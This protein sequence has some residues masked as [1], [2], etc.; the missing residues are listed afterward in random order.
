LKEEGYRL[1]NKQRFYCISN[2]LTLIAFLIENTMKKIYLLALA[3]SLCA[4]VQAQFKCYSTEV[5]NKRRAQNPAFDEAVKREDQRFIK[6]IQSGQLMQ[7]ANHGTRAVKT[8]PVVVHVIWNT[9][10][11]NVTDASIQQM[12][13]TLNQDFS[14]QNPTLNT[15]AVRASFKALSKDAEIQFCLAS[16]TPAGASTTGISRYNTSELDY[17]PDTEEDKM[18]LTTTNGGT[19]EAAWDPTK[20]LNIWICDLTPGAQGQGSVGGYAYR[21]NG[22]GVHGA[23]YDGLVIDYQ[24]GMGANNHVAT[25]EIG[26]YMGLAHT[27]G[28]NAGN[29]CGNVYPATDDGFSETPDSKEPNYFCTKNISC[30]GNHVDGDMYENYMDYAAACMALFT[31]QQVAYMNNILSGT[32]ASLLTSQGCVAPNAPPVASFTANRQSICSGQT[33]TF[34]STSTG[35]P[36]SYSWSFPG[37][38]PATSTSA[39]PTITYSTSGTYNVSLTVTNGFGSNTKTETAFILVNTGGGALPLAEGF[40][41]TTFPPTGWTLQ[42]SDA[43]ITWERNASAGGFGTSTASAYMNNVDYSTIGQKDWLITPSY[44]FAGVSAGRLKFEYAYTRFYDASFGYYD[45]SL[46]VLYSTDCGVTWTNLWKKGGASLST[47]TPAYMNTIFLPTAAQWKRDSV[48]LA[49]LSGQANVKFAF[50]GITGYGNNLYLDNINIYN[51]TVVITKPVAD[52]IGTPTTV[53]V[54]N[55]VAFTDLSANAPTSWNWTFAGGTPGTST[56][57]NPTITYNTVGT[58]AVTLTATNTAGSSTPVTKT[59]YITVINATPA[60]DCDTL[61]HYDSD[62]DELAMYGVNGT[63]GAVSGHNGLLDKSKAEKYTTALTNPKVYGGF[64]YFGLAK[65][66]SG[67]GK[68]RAKVWDNTGTGGSPGKALDSVDVLITTL[69]NNIQLD[70]PTEINFPTQPSVTSDFY[71]GFTLTYAAGDTVYLLTSTTASPGVGQGWEQKSNGTWNSY[72]AAYAN[73]LPNIIFPK[74]CGSASAPVAN[75]SANKTTVCAGQPLTFTDLSTGAPTSWSWSFGGGGTPNASSLQ[76]PSVVFNTPGTYTVALTASNANGSNTSTKTAY[77]VVKANPVAT[78]N[79]TPVACYGQSTGSATTTV[80]GGTPTYTYKWSDASALSSLTA[81]PAGLYAVTV[82]DANQC[83]DTAT[84]IISQPVSAVSAVASGNDA[85]CGKNNGSVTTVASGGS[86]GFKYKWNTG[87]TTATVGSLYAGT[88]TVT[89]TDAKNCTATTFATITNQPSNVSVSVSVTGANCG[90][91][92]GSVLASATSG[93]GGISQVHYA[94][95]TGDTT[96]AV[97]NLPSGTYNVTVTNSIGCTATA[98]GVINNVPAGF[99]VAVITA[100]ATCGKST[101]TATANI[102]NGGGSTFTYLWSNTEAVA[103]IDSL[104][105]GSYSVT[106]TNSIGCSVVATGV[107]NNQTGGFSASVATTPAACSNA[108]GT[109]TVTIANGGGNTFT[110]LWSFN[111]QTTPGINNLPAGPYT[112]TVTNTT[113]CSTTASGVVN[114]QASN[115]LISVTTT[116]ASCGKPNGT[117]TVYITNGGSGNVTYK[118]N[119][120]ETTTVIDSLAIGSYSVTATDGLGCTADAS[121]SVGNSNINFAVGVTTTPATCGQPNGTATVAVTSGGT[122]AVTYKWNTTQT[123]AV[124]SNLGAGSY[125][126]TATDALGCTTSAS[127]TVGSQ[128]TTFSAAVATT[129]AV[130]GKPN[131]TATVNITN[132]SGGSYT[133][134]WN[135][136]E[137]ASLIDSLPAGTYSVTVTNTTGCTAVASGTISAPATAISVSVAT[138]NATCSKSNGTAT[139]TVTNAAGGAV[140]YQ[141]NTNDNAAVSDSLSGGTYSVTVTNTAGCSATA[142]GAVV[143]QATGFTVSVATADAQCGIANGTATATINNTGTGNISLV[144]NTGDTT[145]HISGLLPGTYSVVA[146]DN[147]GCSGTASA[148]LSNISNLTVSLTGKNPTTATAADGEVN[149]SVA[150]G[151]QPYSYSWSTTAT[152][153]SVNGLAAGT[154]TL[155][156]TDDAGCIKIESITLSA[157]LAV[158]NI[159]LAAI[160]V[161]PNP[162]NEFVKI[163]I[164]TALNADLHIRLTDVPG[165]ILREINREDYATGTEVIDLS[166]LSSGMYFIHIDSGN[167][168][169]TIRIIKQ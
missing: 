111:S 155:T 166:L 30:A 164:A 64:Y 101:G 47:T 151:T 69:A 27:W 78:T 1:I 85:I 112:V 32:R 87:D 35:N 40:Q 133:Y 74:V 61:S 7:N 159:D 33:V 51:S 80:T 143:A 84:A 168:L 162:A 149:S 91:P 59:A 107:V 16:R 165:R 13:A 29:A 18:K 167:S 156:V 37:G 24:L 154:Y 3:I 19:G 20:Y 117:A 148:V 135:N 54:G 160:L 12:M 139:A 90:L 86:G 15:S 150:G 138:V 36:T 50:V 137:T 10:A 161:Y 66:A 58:Y 104:P 126:V 62:N 122:G 130:C 116:P 41:S 100:P 23:Y 14:N 68:I 163:E 119:N 25:H 8:I 96:S 132:G 103:S 129:N 60:P 145:A 75:F 5:I 70:L 11:E 157:P 95:N 43:D 45:D 49:S 82:T 92:N 136:S 153:G 152:S 94:W 123:I 125:S 89:I 99:S 131:G 121:G 105:Q 6:L 44:S 65:S 52:F 72:V 128:A 115:F 140:T 39:N 21:P 42:N 83:A 9:A 4:S 38:S 77:I 67:T 110:Y 81:K 76:S 48:S 158:S 56:T 28:D 106:V 114:S 63:W 127:G 34:T 113:G 2:L 118:W 147:I 71:I 109:A 22:G 17:D 102:T 88:Y 31:N 144:W 108:T 26:H 97:I 98:S 53:V 79:V 93:G 141:W 169:R 146:T 55:S 134:L 124:I 57:Q 142:S 46:Q 73:D 120:N